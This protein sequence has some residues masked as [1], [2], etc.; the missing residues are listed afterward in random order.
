MNQRVLLP[1]GEVTAVPFLVLVVALLLLPVS[2]PSAAENEVGDGA[3]NL[4]TLQP[5][6]SDGCSLFPDGNAKENELW[7]ECCIAHDLAYWAGGS[8]AERQAADEALRQ[9]VAEVGQPEVAMMMLM[10]VRVGGSPYLDT[11]FRWGYGWP[12]LTDGEVR[13]YKSLSTAERDQVEKRRP[14]PIEKN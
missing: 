6:R 2:S 14:Q 1:F 11:P 9:C 8:Y 4:S 5:F 13:G 7:L 12:Y 10:G 3:D